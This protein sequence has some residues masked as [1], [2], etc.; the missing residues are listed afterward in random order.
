MERFKGTW[1]PL[2]AVDVSPL[3]KWITSIPLADWPQQDRLSA[4]YPYPAMVSNPDW[5]GF[6]DRTDPLVGR[7]ME[8]FPGMR[9]D[10]RMLS[11]V[12]PGQR[13]AEH[14]DV[15]GE[16]WR[17]RVHVPL[18]TNPDAIMFFGSEGV[19]LDV[20]TAYLVNTEVPHSLHNLGSDPRIH[21]FFDVRS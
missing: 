18:V 16:D 6:K 21:F 13:I 5:C 7:I 15:Q 20:G 1:K 19:H 17:V 3:V 14:D 11:I 9:P 8:W 10:H 2:C 12:I 4:D